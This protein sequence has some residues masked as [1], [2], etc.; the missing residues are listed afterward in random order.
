M[1]IMPKLKEVG[2]RSIINGPESFTPDYMPLFGD[3][4]EV[5]S[6]KIK[7][8]LKHQAMK[9]LI[10]PIVICFSVINSFFLQVDG[11]YLNCAMNSR[12]IQLSGGVGKEMANLIVDGVTKIDMSGYSITR[13]QDAY[14]KN[15]KWL[16]E[17]THEAIVSI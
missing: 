8:L 5:I 6:S 2:Y 11:L 9:Q 16:D 1:D 15:K 4:P 17:Y 10:L 13:F 14:I 12:G 7:Q 3:V